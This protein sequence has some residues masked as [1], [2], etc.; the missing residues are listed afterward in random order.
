MITLMSVGVWPGRTWQ[1]DI[2]DLIT[3]PCSGMSHTI[4][5]LVEREGGREG[6]REGEREE[7]ERD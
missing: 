3:S 7:R 5:G 4:G 2:G 1:E 6:G